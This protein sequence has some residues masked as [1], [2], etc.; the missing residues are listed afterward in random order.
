MSPTPVPLGM[1]KKDHR[2][3]RGGQASDRLAGLILAPALKPLFFF[4]HSSLR[5]RNDKANHLCVI[6]G[7]QTTSIQSH[8]E[9]VK[10]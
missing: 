8:V 2:F 5:H 10:A 7:C 1:R 3:R 4:S 6:V 9:V